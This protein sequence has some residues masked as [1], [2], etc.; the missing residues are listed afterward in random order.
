VLE[1]VLLPK[2]FDSSNLRSIFVGMNVERP[3][4]V[5]LLK[6][7]SEGQIETL[8]QP[9]ARTKEWSQKLCSTKLHVGSWLYTAVLEQANHHAVHRSERHAG[10][11]QEGDSG[12]VNQSGR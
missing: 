3:H 12:I 2:A 8:F 5:N 4:D 1:G 10:T 7:L 11:G 9:D 6:G